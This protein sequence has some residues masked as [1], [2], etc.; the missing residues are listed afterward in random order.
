MTEI[1]PLKAELVHGQS[2]SEDQDFRSLIPKDVYD[3]CV[4]VSR[5]GFSLTLVGGAV[6]DWLLTGHVP[7]D[8][9]F[10]LR[11]TFE[12]D[13]K[14]WSFRVNRLG[15]R[16]RE[17]YRYQVEFLSFSILRVTWPDRDYEAELGP[18]RLED[19]SQQEAYGHS[20]FQEKLV[21]SAPYNETFKRRDFTINAMGIEFG[22]PQTPDEFTFIDPF[23]A[24][25]DLKGRV[26][27]NCSDDFHK[28][29]VR[30]CR[31][32][33]FSQKY[34]MSFSSEIENQFS[35]FNLEQLSLFYF[36]REAFK[37]DFFHFMRTF[38][39][40]VDEHN[41]PLG[42]DLKSLE[43]LS[44]LEGENLQLR[45]ERDV[46]LFMVY[47]EDFS[48]SL[49]RVE[50]FC[51]L[52][53]CKLSTYQAHARFKETLTHLEG[54]D[55]ETFKSKVSSLSWQEFLKIEEIKDLKSFHQFVSRVG[56]D[57]LAILGRLNSHLYATFLKVYDVLP[58]VLRG[59]SLFEELIKED[60]V[61]P[62][63]RG[64]LTYYAHFKELWHSND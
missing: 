10:E 3:L 60:Q 5:E 46:L 36:F 20:D 26:L 25:E 8:L 39:Q 34:K 4:E 57:N 32:I 49:E 16:L 1:L 62:A 38:Y 31:A 55:A 35:Q 12:Y 41:I 22:S 58:T 11:H 28:D 18:A 29:P 53:K 56:R 37:V 43:F 24:I 54:F 30:F 42:N 64:E 61:E 15:E 27:K 14:D 9:D 48:G 47:H 7:K 63:Q 44:Q 2:L 40:L 50:L 21:S 52:A 51:D 23:N 33:R 19:Y 59:K 13:E 45:S 17:I 6:R